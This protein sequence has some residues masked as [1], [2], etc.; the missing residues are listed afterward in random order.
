MR[1][2]M[3]ILLL[4]SSAILCVLT[5][6]YL[7]YSSNKILEYKNPFIRVFPTRPIEFKKEI[8]LGF[9]SYY[10]AGYD[11]DQIYLG[12][13]TAPLHAIAIDTNFNNVEKIS[14]YA[15]NSNF[16]FHSIKLKVLPPHFFLMD[17][18]VPAVYEGHINIWEAQL[19]LQDEPY[20]TIAEPMDSTT[21]VF[22][23]NKSQNGHNVL[24]SFDL[25]S[26][27]EFKLFEGLLEKQL[28]GDGIFDTDGMLMYSKALSKIVYIYSYRNQY[29]IAEKSGKFNFSRHTIDTT[30]YANLNVVQLNKEKKMATPPPL[31]NLK[32]ALY[33]NF[34]FVNSAPRGKYDS[35]N[36]WKSSST[37]DVYDFVKGNYL[38]SYYI[39]GINGKKLTDF[40]VTHT[41]IFVL[42]D[43]KLISYEV[44]GN[45]KIAFENSIY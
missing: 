35:L 41:H 8:D 3:L 12:N 38:F 32:S 7:S 21:F 22:R 36:S 43:S 2:K 17:G 23:A 40:L 5:V 34:I 14:I 29:I 15:E 18:T 16:E 20:F 13:Y 25:S 28:G 44:Q 30:E 42:M 31:V 10:F 4:F 9:N 37:I 33:K 11:K 6:W 24:G 1:T 39:V 27:N 26:E 19:K 45:L